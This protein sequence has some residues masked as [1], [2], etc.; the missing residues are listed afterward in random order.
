MSAEGTRANGERAARAS[1]TG[2]KISAGPRWV[3]TRVGQRRG[4]DAALDAVAEAEEGTR[5]G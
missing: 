5:V 1:G 4:P 2:E 3:D